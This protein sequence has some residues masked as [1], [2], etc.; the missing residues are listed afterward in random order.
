MEPERSLPCS[1]QHATGSYPEPDKSIPQPRILLTVKQNIFSKWK[2][3]LNS[4]LAH[5]TLQLTQ[6]FSHGQGLHLSRIE[7]DET[8]LD[9]V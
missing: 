6:L 3:E 7:E 8:H 1:Q 9:R 2:L 4:V 5:L